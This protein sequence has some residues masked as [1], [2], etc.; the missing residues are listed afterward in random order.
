MIGCEKRPGSLIMKCAFVKNLIF[1]FFFYYLVRI[2]F[3]SPCAGTQCLRYRYTA[4]ISQGLLQGPES[5]SLL[6]ANTSPRL[7]IPHRPQAHMLKMLICSKHPTRE[8]TVVQAQEQ[9]PSI[10]ATV[11]SLA[12]NEFHL[13]WHET[14]LLCDLSSVV[15]VTW[16]LYF[17]SFFFFLLLE[18]LLHI[19]IKNKMIFKNPSLWCANGSL[20]HSC[21]PRDQAWGLRHA[22][23]GI[24]TRETTVMLRLPGL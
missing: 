13:H 20:F 23:Q 10:R 19:S 15:I 17:L 3:P 14:G 12:E 16:F 2:S 8:A 6:S 4:E 18:E 11:L 9:S 1:F 24:T 21:C 7:W 22:R 5:L